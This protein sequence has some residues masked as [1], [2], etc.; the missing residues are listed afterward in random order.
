MAW[1]TT[2][3]K[4]E[5]ILGDNY[6]G[7]TRLVGFINTANAL[8]TEVATCA[9]NRQATLSSTLLERIECWLAAHFYGH[10]DQFYKEKETGK[11]RAIFQG[12][13]GMG[14]QSTQYGQTAITLD[15]SGCLKA[16]SEGKRG[17]ISWLGLPPSE[18]TAYENRD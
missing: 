10:H 18:Q 14:L 12:E 9:A 16:M 8:T 13:T 2:A 5:D 15:T 6:D 1:R 11:A 17:S 4:V 3:P 7:K